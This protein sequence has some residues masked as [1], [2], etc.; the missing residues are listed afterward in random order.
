MDEC[1]KK[2][3]GFC[4]RHKPKAKLP[5]NSNWD[6]HLLAGHKISQNKYTHFRSPGQLTLT[7]AV[8]GIESPGSGSCDREVCAS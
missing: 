5:S 1:A 2:Y 4:Q 7:G 6:S 3:Q 8:P